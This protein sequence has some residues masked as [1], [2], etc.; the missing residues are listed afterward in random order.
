MNESRA[1][2]PIV[3]SRNRLKLGLFGLNVSN[4]CSMTEMPGTLKAEWGESVRLATRADALG[5]EA[6]I[7]V[8]RW[9]GMGGA[10]NFNNRNFETFT[11]AAGLSALTRNS[12]IFA[13][14]HVP[15]A[16][17]VR[18][19]KEVATIDHI[20]GGR[21]G[22]NIVAGWNAKEIGMFGVEQREHDARYDYADEW[23]GLCKALW[24]RDEPF[25]WDG[26]EFAAQGLVSMPHPVQR[27]W[28]ALMS[29]GNSARGQRFAAQ[30]ADVN[31]VVA[32]T[33]EAAGK[34]AAETRRIAREEFGREI[35]VFGQAAIVCRETTAEAEEYLRHAVHERGDWEGVRNL[36][37]VLIPNSQSALGD[38]WEALAANLIGGYGAIPLVGTA[39]EVSAGLGRFADAGLDGVTLSWIDYDAGLAQFETELLPRL[40]AA[41]LRE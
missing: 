32:P 6:I 4:G 33:I 41:G 7:P 36:L 40:R 31:F 8:A 14:F 35:Q 34:I 27:P 17:P 24:T 2:N 25:D 22:L 18:A 39:D 26:T 13:T 23:I 37:D 38:G 16:H 12:A 19:A 20:S 29:A 1:T 9:K 15:T 11:W 30:H 5:F 10:V 21:F 3:S 28:P